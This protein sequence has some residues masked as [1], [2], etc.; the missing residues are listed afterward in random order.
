MQDDTNSM[1]D[2]IRGGID[3]NASEAPALSID[4]KSD[5]VSIVGDP[6]KVDETKG[7]YTITF[8]YNESDLSEEDKVKMKKSEFND[9]E[10][11]AVVKY[12]DKRVKPINRTTIAMILADILVRMGVLAEDGSYST[13][14]MNNRTVRVF[15]ENIEKIGEIARMTLDI[16]ENQVKYISPDSLVEFFLSLLQNEPNIIKESASFLEPSLIKRL[17]TMTNETTQPQNTQQ[18]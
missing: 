13:D 18:N 5:Q 4:P 12:T 3:N 15:L 14:E 8:V 17:A 1:I 11:E 10:Y 16:P 9:D 6:N 7:E 2:A